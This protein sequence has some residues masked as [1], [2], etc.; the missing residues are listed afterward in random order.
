MKTQLYVCVEQPQM[1]SRRG[2]CQN[3]PKRPA[4]DSQSVKARFKGVEKVIGH[5]TS[6]RAHEPGCET[7]RSN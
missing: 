1:S 6:V 3:G 7:G 5:A 4:E 2:G